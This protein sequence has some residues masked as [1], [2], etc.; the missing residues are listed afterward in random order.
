LSPSGFSTTFNRANTISRAE[1]EIRPSGRNLLLQH[2]QDSVVRPVKKE[3]SRFNLGDRVHHSKFGNGTIVAVK[4]N[5]EDMTLQVA[6]LQG[7]IK[8]FLA[9]LAPLKKI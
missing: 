7:G 4:G 9:S 5:G 2:K 6:F 3:N 1:S 8:N